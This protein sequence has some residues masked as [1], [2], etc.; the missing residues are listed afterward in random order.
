MLRG[1]LYVG[2][3]CTPWSRRDK[4]A[5]I[6]YI[7]TN[8]PHS[9]LSLHHLRV[10]RRHMHAPCDQYRAR[11]CD[12][13]MNRSRQLAEE[14]S[15]WKRWAL[16]LV[17]NCSSSWLQSLYNWNRIAFI[18]ANRPHAWNESHLVV[19]A[20]RHVGG[21]VAA[22]HVNVQ[23]VCNKPVLLIADTVVVPVE[24][25]FCVVILDEVFIWFG[26]TL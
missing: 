26:S 2:V 11:R 18:N 4:F 21:V 19:D 1:L 9:V 17:A 13:R 23:L 5:S 16:R 12:H 25:Q 22:T 8:K 20:A 15:A 14:A 3:R 6:N 10:W 24:A 7:I